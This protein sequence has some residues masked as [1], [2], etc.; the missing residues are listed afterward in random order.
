M[1][2]SAHCGPQ[3]I[4]WLTEETTETLYRLGGM[5]GAQGRADA[6]VASLRQGLAQARA[7]A[8]RLPR[9]PMQPQTRGRIIAD[10]ARRTPA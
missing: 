8:A 9:R 3:R 4:I 5:V 7:A 6:L 10:A 2:N 1:S